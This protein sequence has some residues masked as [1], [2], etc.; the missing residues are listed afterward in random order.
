VNDAPA[1]SVVLPV[2]RNQTT[3]DELHRRLVATME[4]SGRPFEILFVNDACPDGSIDVLRALAGR[5][6]RVRVVALEVRA[7][8]HAALRTGLAHS[9]GRVVVTLDA[10]LQDPPEA[11]PVLLAAL[12]AGYGAVYAGRRGR[13]EHPRRLASSWVF[14]H[15]LS[16]VAGMP[17]D[18]G[19]FIAM[20]RDV[21]DRVVALP[22]RTPF[23][24][25]AVAFAGRPVASVPV[26]RAP[27]PDGHSSY[28][29]GMRLWTAVTA[30]AQAI[31]WR[32][33][34]VAR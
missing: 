5:D 27:R 21:A 23:I 17:A 26:V 28:T 14:K 2:Y 6:P 31:R 1:V 20:R 4:A 3:L 10:D 7:G 29:A 9:Y 32:L 33:T 19:A 11:I 22:D 8:Q 25:A 18:A 16:L 13:Y 24:T 15:A 30:L 12:D 34:G